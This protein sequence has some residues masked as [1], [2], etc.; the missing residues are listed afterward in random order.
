MA[1]ISSYCRVLLEME[2]SVQSSEEMSKIKFKSCSVQF[3][4]LAFYL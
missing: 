3:Y 4:T 2:S 1:K